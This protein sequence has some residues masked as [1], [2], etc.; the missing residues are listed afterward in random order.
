[1]KNI[2]L[3]LTAICSFAFADEQPQI[4][5]IQKALQG[6][7]PQALNSV[8]IADSVY[9]EET[10]QV[11]NGPLDLISF[12]H[13][14]ILSKIESADAFKFIYRFEFFKKLENGQYSHQAN[15]QA[16]VYKKGQPTIYQ[17]LP[18]GTYSD[19]KEEE[20]DFE[21]PELVKLDENCGGLKDCKSPLKAKKISFTFV[22]TYGRKFFRTVIGSPEV[23]FMASPL[24]SCYTVIQE[25]QIISQC[26]KV[27]D[28]R[29]SEWPSL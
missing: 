8:N 20:V 15:D 24:S 5:K 3:I 11:N 2:F 12:S 21:I 16:S 28:F 6:L 19:F 17:Q 1:M 14:T 27:K 7:R 29:K 26:L 22:D 9:L 13:T 25:Y 10:L 23:P 4:Y 18:A